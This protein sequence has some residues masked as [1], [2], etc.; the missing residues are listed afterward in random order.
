MNTC[1]N[2]KSKTKNP[3][4]CSKSCA[5]TYN[6]KHIPKRKPKTRYCYKCK[7]ILNP[8]G[9][10][11]KNTVCK[12]CNKNYVEWNKITL[13]ELK[14]HRQYQKHSRIRNMSRSI[15]R[16]SK[17]PKHCVICG[18]NIHYEVCHIKPIS[19]F[20]ED[21]LISEINNIDNLISLCPN[22]HWELDNNI[23]NI[24]DLPI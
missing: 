7:E 19:E 8:N 5:A 14:S 17:K 10:V 6:N 21:S 16:R 18:Y 15:Y 9:K 3:K 4:F 23:L 20:S 13:G 11:C 2:C 24:N 12:K 22:H 1:L